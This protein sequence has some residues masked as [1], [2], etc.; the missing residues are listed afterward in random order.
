M[1]EWRLVGLLA[2]ALLAAISPARAA[3][4]EYAVEFTMDSGDSTVELDVPLAGSEIKEVLVFVPTLDAGSTAT[5]TLRMTVFDDELTPRGWT[6]KAITS[7]QDNDVIQCNSS[8]LE[9]YCDRSVTIGVSTMG[10]AQAAD[11]TFKA[12]FIVKH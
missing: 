5:I 8:A 4:A 10:D 11:R 9:V 2:A 6:D 1:K 7:T 12:L 3:V